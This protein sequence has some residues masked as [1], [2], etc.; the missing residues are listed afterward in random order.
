MRAASAA[1]SAASCSVP[2]EPGVTGTPAS[3]AMR[4]AIALSP[5]IAMTCGE[6]PMKT[7]PAS[8]TMRAKAAFSD[9]KP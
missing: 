7:S 6:G 2:P 9:R 3:A 5:I 4:R 1:A 8:P